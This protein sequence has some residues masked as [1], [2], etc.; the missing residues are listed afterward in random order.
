[1]TTTRELIDKLV[2][3]GARAMRD[4]MAANIAPLGGTLPPFDEKS[5]HVWLPQSRVS[6]LAFLT[7]LEEPS[8]EM[9]TTGIV[10]LDQTYHGKHG[11]TVDEIWR[12][13]L[14][15]LHKEIE[16]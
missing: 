8:E 10:A 6:L 13:M 4:E 14:A 15:E 9:L 12:S 11:W 16:K 5:E 7:V 1:M 2:K 3:A